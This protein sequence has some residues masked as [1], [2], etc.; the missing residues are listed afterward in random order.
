[1]PAYRHSHYEAFVWTL[2]VL[3][4][5]ALMVIAIVS[6][7][8]QFDARGLSYWWLL[9]CVLPF[10]L[11]LVIAVRRLRRKTRERDAAIQQLFEADGFLVDVTPSEAR[12]RN[13]FEPVSHLEYFLELRHGVSRIRWIALRLPGWLLFEHEYNTGSGDTSTTHTRIVAVL[14]ATHPTLRRAQLGDKPW[15][16]LE[17]PHFL[18]RLVL[19]KRKEFTTLGD[20]AFDAKWATIGDAQTARS[21]LT[22]DTLGVL[23]ESP[24]GES[25]VIGYGFVCCAYRGALA[26]TQLRIMVQRMERLLS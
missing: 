19:R 22:P 7:S 15:V 11:S 10:P 23:E 13:V 4:G 5:L 25:W 6:L 12:R 18:Q 17:R 2:I 24:K 21:F 8:F 14:S 1:M 26:P 20:A 9:P 3:A 16:M